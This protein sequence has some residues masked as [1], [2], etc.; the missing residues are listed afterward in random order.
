MRCTQTSG[1]FPTEKVGRNIYPAFFVLEFS[2][3][4]F[5]YHWLVK[6]TLSFLRQMDM[7]SSPC[8]QIWARAVRTKRARGGGVIRHKLIE[9]EQELTDSDGRR[10]VSHPACPLQGIEP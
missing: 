6:L 5:P 9:S 10:T 1:C 3:F 8:A 2:V 7:G 4:V